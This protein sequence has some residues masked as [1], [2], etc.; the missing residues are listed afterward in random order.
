MPIDMTPE[1]VI[2][3]RPRFAKPSIDDGKEVEIAA[4]DPDFDRSH[5]PLSLMDF[6]GPVLISLPRSKR[7][8][9]RRL[10]GPRSDLSCH[11]V[12][13]ACAIGGGTPF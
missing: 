1:K 5:E 4:I 2:D 10:A 8:T 7:S 13:I 12:M 6:A 11:H 9:F 3:G